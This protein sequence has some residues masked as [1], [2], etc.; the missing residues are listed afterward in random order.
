LSIQ[1][2]VYSRVKRTE[3]AAVCK[4]IQAQQ[5][6]T[7][8]HGARPP[9]NKNTGDR[10]RNS[11]TGSVIRKLILLAAL[12]DLMNMILMFDMR[13]YGEQSSRSQQKVMHVVGATNHCAQNSVEQPTSTA[14]QITGSPETYS[15]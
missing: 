8:E 15:T 5:E 7:H 2:K 11:V 10:T 6:F 9:D 1:Y 13:S 4:I 14:I 12:R 3:Q